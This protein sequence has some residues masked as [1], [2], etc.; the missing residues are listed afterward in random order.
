MPNPVPAAASHLYSLK[1]CNYSRVCGP[2]FLVCVSSE[3]LCE[4]FESDLLSSQVCMERVN[5]LDNAALPR[6]CW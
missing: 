4:C 2:T 3:C 6:L 1:K 5:V